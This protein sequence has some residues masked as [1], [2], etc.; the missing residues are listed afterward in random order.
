MDKPFAHGGNAIAVAKALGVSVSSLLDLS[1]SMNPFA[2][3]V[4]SI[5]HN[6]V[7][8]VNYYPDTTQ[9][10]FELAQIMGVSPEEILLTNG[11]SEAIA[12]VAA[13][14]EGAYVK[15]PEFSLY[16]RHLSATDP[17]LPRWRSNPNNPLGNLAQ[18]EEKALVWDEAFFP[19]ASGNWTRGDISTGSIVIGSLTKVFSCPGL[20]IGYIMTKDK[21]LLEKISNSQPQWAL[22]SLALA[23]IPELLA[24]AD[25]KQWSKKISLLKEH[26]KQILVSYGFSPLDTDANWLLVPDASW[27]REPLLARGILVRDCANF[28]LDGVV[29]MA[30]PNEEG[31]YRLNKAFSEVSSSLEANK[32]S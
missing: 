32:T 13:Q 28:G 3:D 27:V 16:K 22:S 4:G 21:E 17:Y 30:V 29:R 5:I 23:A 15:E 18:A 19:L 8:C 11:G 20:R 6:N 1:A 12:L 7:D 10:S 2:P 31:L 24:L 26:L 14:L 25:I 9:A